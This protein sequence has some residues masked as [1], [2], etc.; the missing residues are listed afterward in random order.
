M[1]FALIRPW[2]QLQSPLSEIG[3]RLSIGELFL[4][5]SAKHLY[6]ETV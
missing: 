3:F 2:S 5:N 6:L 4:I 1:C